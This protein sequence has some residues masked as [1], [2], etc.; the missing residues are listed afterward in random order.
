MV[1]ES[2]LKME[3]LKSSKKCDESTGE[4]IMIHK[5]ISDICDILNISVPSVSFDSSNFS[6]DTMMAQCSSDGSTIYVKKYD[7]PNPDQLFSITHELR[8][9]WQIKNNEQLYFSK[10]KPIDMCSSGEE[11]NLQIAELDANAF[12]GLIMIDFFHLKPLFEGIPESVR[13][14]IFERME[15]LK[16]T[17]LFQ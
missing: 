11:Y 7:K 16:T 13:S 9:I 2:D 15:Y 4:F 10:Y 3:Y 17:E 1:V 8:H 14:K 5:F 6:T 12:A